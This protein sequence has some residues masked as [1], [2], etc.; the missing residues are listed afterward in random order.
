[1]A[2]TPKERF[3]VPITP[4]KDHEGGTIIVLLHKVEAID[5]VTLLYIFNKF[6]KIQLFKPEKHHKK[7]SSFYLVATDVQKH[8][9]EAIALLG[10]LKDQ[11]KV[12]TFGQKEEYRTWLEAHALD[13]VQ[14]VE[15]FGEELVRLGRKVWDIQGKG[16][17]KASFIKK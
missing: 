16:L 4:L 9:A 1:M 17:E 12:A 14:L 2:P 13:P 15:E 6:S 10:R 8:H 11:W 5:N 3:T 7:R